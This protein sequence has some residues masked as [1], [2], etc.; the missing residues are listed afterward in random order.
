MFYGKIHNVHAC[1][2]ANLLMSVGKRRAVV[3]EKLGCS[4]KYQAFLPSYQYLDYNIC[5]IAII[6]L[7]FKPQDINS[8][9]A[10]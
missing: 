7:Q 4:E 8:G 1:I 5:H 3:L 9:T 10:A 6:F 2:L